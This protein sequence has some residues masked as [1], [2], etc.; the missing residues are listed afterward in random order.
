MRSKAALVWAGI[1]MGLALPGCGAA[2]AQT[3]GME[4]APELAEPFE[5]AG[6]QGTFLL[7]DLSAGR[8]V[9]HRLD[10]ADTPAPPAS[11]FKIFNALVALETGAIAGEDV[12]IPWD[13]VRRQLEAWNQD[14]SLRSAMRVSAVWFYQELARRIGRERMQHWVDAAGYG[15]RD[16]GAGPIDRF[17]L[18]G[19]LRIT[20]RQQ[21]DL[22]V[23]LYRNDLPFSRRSM[24]LVRDLLVLEKTDRYV[25]RGKTGWAISTAPQVGWFVGYVE[26]DGS[27]VFFAN[28]IELRTPKDAELRISIARAILAEKGLIDP[29]PAR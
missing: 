27:A 14:H 12:L 7:Y 16:L 26:R 23:R 15:N 25:L 13:G 8:L 24:D 1:W 2:L 6:V 29:R 18:D 19:A 5:A 4:P 22:L 28:R 20:P 17:W 10:Q 21:I 9:G 3:S 11:T